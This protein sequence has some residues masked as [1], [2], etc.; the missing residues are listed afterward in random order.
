MVGESSSGKTQ[1]CLQCT[2]QAARRGERVVYLCTEGGFPQVV[3]N[4]ERCQGR[5]VL[6]VIQSELKARLDQMVGGR[7]GELEL[8]LVQQVQ[9]QLVTKLYIAQ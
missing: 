4:T 9:W 1:L 7:R 6:D 3:T 8:V 2:V 5:I